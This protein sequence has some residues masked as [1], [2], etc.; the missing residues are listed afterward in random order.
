MKR[1]V[2][3]KTIKLI[4]FAEEN[5]WSLGRSKGGKHLRFKHKKYGIFFFGQ[6]PSDTRAQ[7]NAIST[8]RKIMATGGHRR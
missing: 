3:D 4:R 7:Q 2:N 5:G 1:I 8:M 6:S